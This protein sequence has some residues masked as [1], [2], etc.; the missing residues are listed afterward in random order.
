MG[1]RS[2]QSK[3]TTDEER[4]ARTQQ[5]MERQQQ[6]QAV[7]L[8]YV[9]EFSTALTAQQVSKFFEVENNMQKKLMERRMHHRKGMKA[10][11]PMKGRK[12]MQAPKDKK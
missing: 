12:P 1:Q 5:R 2:R 10:R 11:R 8:K 7:R 6:A 9:D 4:L 3:P